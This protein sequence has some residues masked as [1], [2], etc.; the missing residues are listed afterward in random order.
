MNKHRNKQRRL[1]ISE[2]TLLALAVPLLMAG[3][4]VHAWLKN[5]HVQVMRD[6]DKTE[7]RIS[8]HEDSINSL[9]VKIDRKLNIYQIRDD[10]ASAGSELRQISEVDPVVEISRYKSAGIAQSSGDSSALAQVRP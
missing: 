5:S 7:Q 2:M 9:Q 3:G 10:L 8:D 1:S 4:F 6:I